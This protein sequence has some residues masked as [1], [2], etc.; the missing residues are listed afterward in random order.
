MNSLK[1][2]LEH[3]TARIA[4]HPSDNLVRPEDLDRLDAYAATLIDHDYSGKTPAMWNSL[5]R[6]LKMNVRNIMIVANPND[7]QVVLDT[8]R[9]DPKYM[10]G[11]AGSG[12]KERVKP[13]L[14]STNP[15]DV[16]SV[17]TIVNQNGR[18]IGYN[19]DS[20]GLMLS[21]DDKLKGIGKSVK[22]SAFVVVGAGGVAQQFVRNLQERGADYVAV[23]N[24]TKSKAVDMVSMINKACGNVCEAFGEDAVEALLLNKPIIA[25][26]NTSEKGGDSLPGTTMFYGGE[27]LE[28][29][30]ALVKQLHRV[31]PNLVYGCILLPKS[32][33]SRSLQVVKEEG[34]DD[35]F[36]LDGRPM[37]TNQAVPGFK[38]VAKAHPRLHPELPSVEE[39][40]KIF[41]EAAYK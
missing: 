35:R 28:K 37:V 3:A 40:L 12:F 9:R 8:L 11:G 36:I 17:N 7:A 20:D 16:A 24:R 25:I 31:K 30:R 13:F 34:I 4:S 6:R 38:L 19:T 22:G 41:V 23:A 2:L 33:V 15:E 21:L 18:L 32:G 29:S 14:D 10:G 5:Y 26:I 1:E 39:M 27:S